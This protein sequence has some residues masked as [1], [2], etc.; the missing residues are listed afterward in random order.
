M[1]KTTKLV[2][3][4]TQNHQM[5]C[6]EKKRTKLQKKRKKYLLNYK[7]PQIDLHA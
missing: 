4:S 1:L 7:Y 3:A 2:S 6:N 5:Y